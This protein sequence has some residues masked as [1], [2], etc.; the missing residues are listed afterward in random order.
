[1]S[2]I[3]GKVYRFKYEDVRAFDI[4]VKDLL[5]LPIKELLEND[6]R[7]ILQASEKLDSGSRLH[8]EYLY[9]PSFD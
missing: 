6:R 8:I 9:Q 2:D 1:M 7:I 4:E 5:R 3:P